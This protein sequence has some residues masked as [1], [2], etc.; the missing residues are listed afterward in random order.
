MPTIERIDGYAEELTAIRRDLHAHPEIG[1][2]EVRTSGIVA[3]KLKG[4]VL[5][6]RVD[7]GSIGDRNQQHVRF[8]NG[9]PA[10]DRGA[11]K[12][13]PVLKTVKVQLADGNGRVLPEAGEIHETKVHKFDLLLLAKFQHIS[14]GH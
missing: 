13:K 8:V 4:C 12:T 3:E 2:E 11:V 9:T 1:F 5:E 14:G 10:A 6:E 7:L